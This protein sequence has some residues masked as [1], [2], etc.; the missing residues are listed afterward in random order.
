MV[1][2]K[3]SWWVWVSCVV[4]SEICCVGGLGVL[5]IGSIL[6]VLLFGIGFWLG[7][8]L[9]VWLFLFS[10]SSIRLKWLMLCRMVV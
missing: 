6:V 10:L 8:R 9:V 2:R 5:N 7:N 1:I 3:I 4:E